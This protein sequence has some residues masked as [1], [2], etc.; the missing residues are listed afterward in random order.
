MADRFAGWKPWL[1]ASAALRE[2]VFAIAVFAGILGFALISMDYLISGGPDWNPGPAPA[3]VL[4]SPAHATSLPRVAI[5]EPPPA[6]PEPE[7]M[8]LFIPTGPVGDLLGDRG[9]AAVAAPGGSKAPTLD[10]EEFNRAVDEISARNE[11]ASE[12]PLP[13]PWAP[14]PKPAEF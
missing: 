5:A 12:P 14:D 6:P 8:E 7:P 9:L 4:A 13:P 1:A 11:A 2:Q 10:D 3:Q